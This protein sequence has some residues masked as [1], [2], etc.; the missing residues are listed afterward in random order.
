VTLAGIPAYRC[1]E[2][3][4]WGIVVSPDGH[5]TIPC[6]VTCEAV[7]PTQPAPQPQSGA[8]K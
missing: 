6:P 8:A 2:C 1:N 4:D 3:Q 7:R 5:G